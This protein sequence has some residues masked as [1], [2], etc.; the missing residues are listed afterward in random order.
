MQSFFNILQTL[1]NKK[2]KTYPDE[3]FVLFN[4]DNETMNTKYSYH[5]DIL[6]NNIYIFTQ[7]NNYIN[8]NY[9]TINS[10]SKLF[11]LTT[12]LSN[13]F[14]TNELKEYIFDIFSKAQKHYHAF[15][16]L[17]LLYKHKTYNIVVST[18]LMLTPLDINHKSTFKI[19]EHKYIYLFN[20]NDI[21]SIVETSIGNAPNFFLEPKYPVNPYNNQ[22]F[23]SSTL[24]NI[25]FKL[26]SSGRLMSTLFHLFFLENFNT[27]LFIKKYEHIV[28]NNAIKKFV[29]NS[30]YNTLYSSTIN[31]LNNNFYTSKLI[32]HEDFPKNILVDIFRPFLY[33]SYII[34]YDILN[35]YIYNYKLTLNYKLRQFYE[36]NHSFG[37]RICHVINK[38]KQE[39]TF[40]TDYTG[41]YKLPTL[42]FNLHIIQPYI[43]DNASNSETDIDDD[44]DDDEYIDNDDN[45]IS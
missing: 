12:M 21:V 27:Q 11:A 4:R 10:Y 29:F 40:N 31:M 33:Y 24:Y 16:R 42:H 25:Y 6:I 22:L 41:F 43:H 8:T 39:Y 18:D 13:S 37:R 35:S 1:I 38:T 28:R 32:I 20:I 3:P 34:N 15:S 30:P 23:S 45:S 17:A 19:V 14:Y 36:Y 5:I 44:I 9:H 2:Y 26:K 7:N